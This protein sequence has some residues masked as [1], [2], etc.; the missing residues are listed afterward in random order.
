MELTF[1][2]R[3][4]AVDDDMRDTATHKLERLERLEP[5]ITRIDLAFVN[6]H[7]PT[8]DGL[9]RV[10]A[11]LRIPRKTFFAHAEAG[12]VPSALDDVAEKL[13]RQLRDH[14]GKRRRR[15]HR[16]LESAHLGPDAA[17]TSE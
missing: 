13:E 9:K 7:H 15:K 4:V 2:G 3:G 1:T 12:D 10:H 5:R 16:G 8:L 14:H 11:T 6:E 17:D